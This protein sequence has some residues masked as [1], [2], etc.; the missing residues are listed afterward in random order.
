[1]KVPIKFL[2]IALWVIIVLQNETTGQ[3]GRISFV[4]PEIHK[5]R[6][7]TFRF[8]A[9]NAREVKL[10]TQFING[11]QSLTKDDQGLWSITLGPV[12]PDIYPYCFIVDGIQLADPK[13]SLALSPVTVC[14]SPL[15]WWSISSTWPSGSSRPPKRNVVRRTPFAIAPT[16]P[17]L[18]VYTWR[19]RSDSAYRIERRTTASVL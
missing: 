6:T 19:I 14:S 10:S 3:P 17:R 8:M 2:V 9:P 13:N 7:V 5:D 16:R 11:Q 1:M 4:S 15:P 12:E 18:A